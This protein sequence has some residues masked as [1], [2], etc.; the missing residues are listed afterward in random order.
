M[1]INI[2]NK[3][4]NKDLYLFLDYAESGTTNMTV[5]NMTYIQPWK[6]DN[7]NTLDLK[8]PFPLSFDYLNS[9]TFWYII[10]DEAGAATIKEKPH[11]AMGTG[12]PNWVGG[13]FELSYV[14]GA[15]EAYFDVTNV[16]QVGLFC[17]VNFL[18]EK[19]VAT[20]HAGYGK[21]ADDMIA[22]LIT[23]CKLSADTSAKYTINGTDGKTYTNLLGPTQPSVSSQYNA[24]YKDYINAIAANSTKI[25]IN[26]DSTISNT[27][28][29]GGT[30]LKS[31]EF[32]G[33][34]GQPDSMPK[35][36][37][38]DAS[39][40]VLYFKCTEEIN[41]NK[42]GED[43][44]IYFTEEAI[45][46]GTIASGNSTGGMYV[47]PAFEYTDPNAKDPAKIQKGGWANN[48]S[49]NW[50][51]IGPNAVKNT[52]CFMAMISS[53]GRDV[54]TAMNLGLIGVTK[55]KNAFT[56]KDSSTYATQAT[57]DKY[58]NQWN[59]YITSNS[60]SYGM[61]YS[62]GTSAKVLFHPSP[63]GTIDC[64]VFGQSDKTTVDYWS[65]EGLA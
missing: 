30:Q 65:A 29:H 8:D 22:G 2:Y 25:T 27:V 34:F 50:T 61:A 55:E 63:N 37:T 62:D 7:L 32:T 51:A 28:T 26:S 14:E 64:Y 57:Q 47:Y 42:K 40:V 12:V 24:G 11:T 43:T 31:F 4:G 13:F 35:G 9:G 36:A 59:K 19:G 48:V 54:V 56:Y 23:A 21:T 46:S 15:T 58:V 60:D 45:N 1:K 39:E 16:D 33:Y 44:Y 38:I 5:D 6:G 17:G 20:G 3:T 10:T 49:L 53:V 18:D 52:T 41:P